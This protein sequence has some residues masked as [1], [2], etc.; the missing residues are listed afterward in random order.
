MA[1]QRPCR[2]P[3]G[4]DRKLQI[5][6]FISVLRS[7]CEYTVSLLD[8]EWR[9]LRFCWRRGSFSFCLGDKQRIIICT[10]A[11]IFKILPRPDQLFLQF[12]PLIFWFHS[13][14]CYFSLQNHQFMT[15]FSFLATVFFYFS[16]FH[17]ICLRFNLSKFFLISKFFILYITDCFQS[18][19]CAS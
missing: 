8:L 17:G 3:G 19:W 1:A 9:I 11:L 4:Q 14:F 5:F 15:C 6:N 10:K 16:S 18:F 7:F 13:L 12:W 2:Q